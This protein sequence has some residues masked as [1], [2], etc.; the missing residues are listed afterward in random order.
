MVALFALAAFLTSSQDSLRFGPQDIDALP[1]ATTTVDQPAGR[2]VIQ[3]PPIVVPP[4]GMTRAPVYRVA[5]PLDVLLYGF[6]AAVVDETGRSLPLDR[7][8][9]FILTDPERS[10]LF[11]PL[12]LP[13]FGVSKE[14]PHPVLPRRLIGVPLPAGTRYLA[15]AMFANPDSL[16]HTMRAQMV[17][18]FVRPG[19][20][21]PLFRAYPWTMDVGY[22]L[23]GEGGRHDYDLPAGRS[24]RGWQ[25]SPRIAG[26]IIGMGG[27][28]HDYATVLQLVDVST[29]DTIWRQVP[30]R[31]GDGH[32]LRI[33]VALFYRWYRLGIHIW[34]SH[35]YRL[36]VCYDNPTGR[37]L[38]FG[39]MGSVIGVLIPARGVR[40][41]AVDRQ[42]PIYRAQINNLLSNM[43]GMDTGHMSMDHR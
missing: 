32:I 14:S 21:F 29:G 31:D 2:L 8:H 40:W 25:G 36:T 5:V 35:V 28:A 38:R 22:P 26:T 16:P 33:P 10:D 1:L 12:A 23:G 24:C 7:L 43:A 15:G 20:L 41:P 4:G 30:E 9:H 17:L 18:S 19:H 39:G 11:L 42:D 37:T 6:D 34:P 3:L 13:I 27:H